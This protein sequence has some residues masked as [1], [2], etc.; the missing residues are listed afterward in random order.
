MSASATAWEQFTTKVGD[1]FT[2]DELLGLSLKALQELLPEY[3]V[4]SAVARAR[5]EIQW[6]VLGGGRLETT[7]SLA[8][9]TPSTSTTPKA[10]ASHIRSPSVTSL[11]SMATGGTPSRRTP[12]SSRAKGST[13]GSTSR[14]STSVP[15]PPARRSASQM[16]APSHPTSTST[17]AVYGRAVHAA[18]FEI[19]TAPPSPSM[20]RR[21]RLSEE[22]AARSDPSS[23]T[24]HHSASPSRRMYVRGSAG[25][26]G[27]AATIRSLSPTAAAHQR[28]Q[29]CGVRSEA[30]TTTTTA[31]TTAASEWTSSKR[32]YGVRS[33][34]TERRVLGRRAASP[35]SRPVRGNPNEVLSPSKTFLR[36]AAPQA[37]TG[38][39]GAHAVDITG[40][41]HAPP[42][43]PKV[44]QRVG[45]A[46]PQRRK[47]SVEAGGTRPPFGVEG[48]T[49]EK[50]VTKSLF[51][52][53]RSSSQKSVRTGMRFIGM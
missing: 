52:P 16:S 10:A 5:V 2:K 7:T 44:E 40:K 11:A 15:I 48:A 21:R 34:S 45:R 6:R 41:R 1:D 47:G 24:M 8:R 29:W 30:T 33:A 13:T 4:A 23:V 9:P 20:Q 35:V 19:P 42:P 17:V 32:Q 12:S 14:R 36:D 50:R 39:V 3:G 46:S 38:P 43:Q 18:P 31:T 28:G 53:T 49:E 25:G 27:E 37:Y 51:M 22:P 26:A